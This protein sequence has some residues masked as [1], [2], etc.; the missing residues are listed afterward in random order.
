MY[1]IQDLFKHFYRIEFTRIFNASIYDL[2]DHLHLSRLMLNKITANK[3]YRL[4]AKITCLS[5][6]SCPTGT[7]LSES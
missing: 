4:H 6:V 1:D 3:I 5:L 2:P 7:T